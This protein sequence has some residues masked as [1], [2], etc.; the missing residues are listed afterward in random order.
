M[1]LDHFIRE[2]YS[3]T[4]NKAQ[5]LIKEWYVSVNTVLIQKPAFTV[6]GDEEILLRDEKRVHWVSR[7]AGKLDGFLEHIWVIHSGVNIVWSTCLDVGSSTGGFTQVLLERWAA[8]VDAVDVGT[9][10]LHVSLRDDPRVTSY[11]KM[12][13]RELAGLKWAGLQIWESQKTNQPTPYNLIVCDASFISL[14]D[15]L[16]SILQLAQTTTHIILLWKPQFEVWKQN[17]QPRWIPKTQKI[18]IQYQKIWEEYL[19]NNNCKIL[20]KEKSI[21]IG[22]TGN[23]EWLYLIQKY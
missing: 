13:I 14:M 18:I 9:D 21:V 2:K 23:E 6:S 5:Q 3:L 8:H 15:I 17:L 20:Q 7:S 12:D 4:G 1:R 16:P 10:Q 22:E 11:E 19:I